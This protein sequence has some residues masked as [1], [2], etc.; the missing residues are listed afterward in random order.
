MNKYKNLN[1]RVHM[2]C[3]GIPVTLPTLQVSN[4]CLV[5]AYFNISS[6]TLILIYKHGY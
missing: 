4:Y 5:S 1:Q 3:D 2:E 6:S